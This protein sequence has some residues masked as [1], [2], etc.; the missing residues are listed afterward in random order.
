MPVLTLYLRQLHLPA[1]LTTAETQHIHLEQ[2][3]LADAPDLGDGHGEAGGLFSPLILDLR[4]EGL[5]GCRVGAVEQVGGDGVGRLLLGGG[6][7]HVALLVLLDGLAHLD[8]LGVALLGVQLGPQAAQVLGIL[9]LLV[10]LA[11][12]LLAGTLVVVEALAV[13]LAMPLCGSGI[14][15][16]KGVCS[17]A[18]RGRGIEEY[19]RRRFEGGEEG[20]YRCTRSGAVVVQAKRLVDDALRELGMVLTMLTVDALGRDSNVQRSV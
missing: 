12:G 17:V 10:A 14:G 9:A 2:L 19:C 18:M 1:S 16:R 15:V 20:A 3:L 8:L 11:G 6:A 7:L 5:G 4:A 13:E